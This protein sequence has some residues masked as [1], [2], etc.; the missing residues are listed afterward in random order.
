MRVFF[1]YAKKRLKGKTIGP[2]GG[3]SIPPE[4]SPPANK[5]NERNWEI[6]YL[7]LP[8]YIKAQRKHYIYN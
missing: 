6:I 8:T 3:A 1:L 5:Y 4:V 7:Y 2:T